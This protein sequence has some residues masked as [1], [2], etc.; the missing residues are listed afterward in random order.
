MS[1]TAILHPSDVATDNFGDS[2]SIS[3]DVVAV[4]AP[5]HGVIVGAAYVF[6]EPAADGLT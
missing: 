4:G 2:V 3:G 6:V 1:Q 5:D